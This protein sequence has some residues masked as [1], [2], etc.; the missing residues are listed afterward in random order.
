LTANI[1]GA[2]NT[3]RHGY[4]AQDLVCFDSN[5]HAGLVLQVHE[6]YLKVITEQNKLKNVKIAEVSKKLPPPR[7]RSTFGVR[8]KQG[9]TL[10]LD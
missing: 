4:S 3:A 5:K 8:D 1:V 2:P 9:N 10:A 7:K 6:D